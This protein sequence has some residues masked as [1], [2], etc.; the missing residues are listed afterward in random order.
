MNALR[1]TSNTKNVA[2]TKIPIPAITH[3]KE[4]LIKIAYSG[5]CGTDLHIISGEFPCNSQV[6][7]GHE[8]SGTVVAFGP[9]VTNLTPGDLVVVDP[10]SG[11][12]KCRF[13]HSGKPHFCPSGGFYANLGVKNDGGWAEYCLCCVE[14]V[15]KLS[16]IPLKTAALVEPLSCVAHGWDLISPIS[17]GEEILVVGAGIIG[18]LWTCLLHLHGHKKLTLVEKNPAR[19]ELL[20][21][22]QQELGFKLVGALEL[23]GKFDLIVDCTGHG[24]AIESGVKLLNFGGKMCIFGVAPP[25]DRIEVSP[26]EIYMK[27][28]TIMSVKVN[29]FSF[30]KAIAL[31]EALAERYLDYDKLGVKLFKLEEYQRAIDCLKN[32]VITKA[33]F[34]V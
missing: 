19:R 15:H 4:V 32:G 7:L 6:T 17:V 8:F 25:G 28:L 27:E 13:C 9:Y 11:C 26:F 34:Q 5:V 10:N 2:L 31:V 1:F 20:K 12:H 33:V 29:S 16:G 24:P 14:Q 21:K 18:I 30:P 3:P 22:L 23:V